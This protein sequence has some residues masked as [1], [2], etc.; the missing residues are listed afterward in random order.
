MAMVGPR[1]VGRS[2]VPLS[3][4]AGFAAAAVLVAIS[5]AA[6]LL[7]HPWMNGA[8]PLI[9]F[10]PAVVVGVW[11][12]RPCGLATTA[13]SI[14]VAS[15]VLV[16][17]GGIVDARWPDR[18]A[19][20]VFAG[21]G[22]VATMVGDRLHRARRAAEAALRIREAFLSI[23]SHELRSPLAALTLQLDTLD[24]ELQH[25]D[26]DLDLMQ[27]TIAKATR[28]T[29]RLDRL[30]ESLLDVSRLA[31]AK[32][33]LE[34]EDADAVEIIREVVERHAE[35][36]RRAGCDL[37]VDAGA[38][39]VGRWDRSRVDQVI[40]N[41]LVNATKYGAGKPVQ[42][43]VSAENGGACIRVRD[44]G[45]GIAE[46]DAQRIFGRFERAVSPANYGGLG[47]G[48]YIADQI[49]Q[50]HGGTLQ[51]A[52]VPGRGAE[53]TVWLPLAPP[54]PR[55]RRATPASHAASPA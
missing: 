4:P 47:L 20:L 11:L 16:E 33:P 23:A 24:H 28:Q 49:V 55:K 13:L 6:G 9:T 50:A 2:Q 14:V 31:G 1:A 17:P 40:T 41:L 30:V 48:L 22:V 43:G 35:E 25:E 26:I 32:I 39:V 27:R 42:V 34:R 44:Q 29:R 38:P 19:L 37:I 7:L 21:I 46:A 15:L 53:F 51:V 3:P 45:I 8:Y 36:A 18:I 52:S 54:V 10:Y 5:T 12:G